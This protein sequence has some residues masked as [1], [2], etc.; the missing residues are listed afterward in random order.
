M[1]K[2]SFKQALISH[3]WVN[4][5]QDNKKP[6]EKRPAPALAQPSRNVKDIIERSASKGADEWEKAKDD[7]YEAYLEGGVSEK[8]M[9]TLF[10]RFPGRHL[11]LGSFAASEEAMFAEL[12][13]LNKEGL[14]NIR[15]NN[16]DFIMLNKLGGRCYH[17]KSD[18]DE[19]FY[20]V[21]KDGENYGI[22]PPDSKTDYELVL[23]TIYMLGLPIS[24]KPD[25]SIPNDMDRKIASA[26][27][28]VLVY[29]N[30]TGGGNNY[31]QENA[32][33][34]EKNEHMKRMCLRQITSFFVE[35]QFE[36]MIPRNIFNYA[37][38]LEYA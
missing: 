29:V 7:W 11:K 25:D 22:Y 35:P 5:P 14:A 8:D 6:I 26:L 17:L 36:R 13:R 33:A 24:C 37:E 10:L 2:N 20:W 1:S 16:M 12:E 3:R 32:S 30:N 31:V 15:I 18:S 9:G 19:G 23:R 38:R 21:L 28:D 4:V 27:V 34:N